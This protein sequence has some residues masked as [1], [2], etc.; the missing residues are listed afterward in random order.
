MT[1][2]AQHYKK[3]KGGIIFFDIQ[4]LFFGREFIDSHVKNF[5]NE[6]HFGVSLNGTFIFGINV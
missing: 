5:W 4:L 2:L 3:R 6:A 1:I